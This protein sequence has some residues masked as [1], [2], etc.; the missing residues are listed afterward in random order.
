MLRV[1]Q[2]V[3]IKFVAGSGPILPDRARSIRSLVEG[4]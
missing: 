3:I 2:T 4:L 1:R